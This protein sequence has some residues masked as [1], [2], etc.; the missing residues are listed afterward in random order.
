MTHLGK[1]PYAFKIVTAHYGRLY[2]S[3][4][5][6][7]YYS[8]SRNYGLFNPRQYLVFPADVTGIVSVP[9]IIY[10]GTKDKIYR[11]SNIDMEGPPVRT[12]VK[13]YGMP[14]T[15]NYVYDIDNN[16]AYANSTKGVISFSSEGI[17]EITAPNLAMDNYRKSIITLIEQDGIKKLIV[18]SQGIEKVSDLK[19]SV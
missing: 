3:V 2:G 9:G 8:N 19:A 17:T 16:I 5:R 6:Y 14:E 15:L 11:I 7:V 4:G 12:E 13:E 18:I 10:V 1:K